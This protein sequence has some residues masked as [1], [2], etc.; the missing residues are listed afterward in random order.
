MPSTGPG[1]DTGLEE[2]TKNAFKKGF[3]SSEYLEYIE[4]AHRAVNH[5]YNEH[6]TFH[7]DYLSPASTEHIL[8]TDNQPDTANTERAQG[9]KQLNKRS[10]TMHQSYDTTPRINK[11]KITVTAEKTTSSEPSPTTQILNQAN[12][13]FTIGATGTGL[14]SPTSAFGISTGEYL[15]AAAAGTA[16]L[17]SIRAAH[18]VKAAY[19]ANQLTQRSHKHFKDHHYDD[20]AVKTHVIAPMIN[21]ANKRRSNEKA[22]NTVVENATKNQLPMTP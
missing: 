7:N 12:D 3:L 10:Q 14:L 18:G 15:F 9:L 1:D 2:L 16:G 5:I 22:I 13:I 17:L 4:G 6:Q 20:T 21:H 8:D 11:D 19:H